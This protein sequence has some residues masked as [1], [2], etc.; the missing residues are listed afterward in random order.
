MCH[1][2][3]LHDSSRAVVYNI[4]KGFLNLLIMP[5]FE[6]RIHNNEMVY[7]GYTIGPIYVIFIITCFNSFIV[8]FLW[9]TDLHALNLKELFFHYW[10]WRSAT[11]KVSQA[12]KHDVEYCNVLIIFINV[13]RCFRCSHSV[14]T[15]VFGVACHEMIRFSTCVWI[16]A[17][18]TASHIPTVQRW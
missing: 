1:N 11:C 16:L 8:V 10:Q 2:F 18:M 6:K 13:L 7:W 5:A 14:S 17:G 15:K 9:I 12:F 4:L 3:N